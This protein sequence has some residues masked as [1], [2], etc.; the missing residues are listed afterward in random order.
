[1][2]HQINVVLLAKEVAHLFVIPGVLRCTVD[3][4][5]FRLL[6]INI[7]LGKYGRACG[8]VSESLGVWV[9]G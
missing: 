8:I 2:F 7:V 9:R 6:H 4:I 1:V 5:G 3:R